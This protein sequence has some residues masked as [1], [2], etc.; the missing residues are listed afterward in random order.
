MQ[1][2]QI[3]PGERVPLPKP[4]I[5]TGMGL[6]RISAVLQGTHDNYATDMMRALIGAVENLTQC[7]GRRPPKGHPQGHRRPSARRGLPCR[8]RRAAVKRGPRLRAPSNYAAGHAPRPDAR[9]EGTPDVRSCRPLCGR[10]G[11]RTPSFSGP[12]RSLPKPFASKRA[13][14]STPLRAAF[15]PRRGDPHL[16]PARACPACCV[17]PVRH[18]WFSPLPTQDASARASSWTHRGIPGRDGAPARR[19][20]RGLAAPRVATKSVL[21]R[22][23]GQTGATEFL[24]YDMELAEGLVLAVLKAGEEVAISR[25]ARAAGLPQSDAF[26]WR[27]GGQVG[28]TGTMT[29]V[30]A[31]PRRRYPEEARRPLRSPSLGR[32]GRPQDRPFPRACRRPRTPAG[33]RA[34]H[35][36]THLLHEA[37]RQ[38]LG[39]HVAQKGLLVAPGRLRFDFTHQKPIG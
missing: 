31:R 4:S 24:G 16:P 26:L 1:Y 28:H 27:S 39:E 14:S 11:W 9:R 25:P 34:N 6:E 29:A 21:V 35:S 15:D 13:G 5:D 33:V 32:E 3:R 18:L 7:L 12:S 36:A 38:V 30:S 19:G 8:R 37:L 22:R 10:W 20:P 2:E 17:H 23:Q